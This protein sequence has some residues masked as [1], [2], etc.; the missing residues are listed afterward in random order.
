MIGVR[1]S[2]IEGLSIN[3]SANGEIAIEESRAKLEDGVSVTD[4]GKVKI[5]GSRIGSE[6]TG[7][8]KEGI[9]V[10]EVRGSQIEGT[11]G[12]VIEEGVGNVL[13]GVKV[14]S[15]QNGI[16]IKG[17]SRA[18]LKD[19]EIESSL[20]G[21]DID[22]NNY[23]KI[24]GIKIKAEEA[25][26]I[27]SGEIEIIDSEI[28]GRITAK[29][30]GNVCINNSSIGSVSVCG[31]SAVGINDSEITGDAIDI[32]EN[33]EVL[34]KD[35]RAELDEGIDITGRGKLKIA[36][37][38]ILSDKTGIRKDGNE[39]LIL[40]DT[41][42]I[43]S[44]ES[45]SIFG[46]IFVSF[47][48]CKFKSYATYT[49]VVIGN[50][51]VDAT[52]LYCSGNKG[53]FCNDVLK[54]TISDF[55]LDVFSNSLKVSNSN[56]VINK[57]KFETKFLSQNIILDG[58]SKVNFYNGKINIDSNFH[59]NAVAGYSFILTT[60]NSETVFDNIDINNNINN[61]VNLFSC[62]NKSNVL[63]TDIHVS[64]F[65]GFM[66]SNDYSKVYVNDSNI[67]SASSSFVL[68]GNSEVFVEKSSVTNSVDFQ[69]VARDCA[70]LFLNNMKGTCDSCFSLERYSQIYTQN[71]VFKVK[72]ESIVSKD[73]AV[74]VNKNAR[75]SNLKN[76]N[77]N[78]LK[79]L[80][81][82]KFNVILSNFLLQI[83]SLVI[84]T[85]N[86]LFFKKIYESIYFMAVKLY[87]V[88]VKNQNI[89]GIFLRRGMLNN[90]WIAGS[91]DID[92]FTMIK[93]NNIRSEIELLFNIHK[94]YKSIKRMFPLYGENIIM[95]Q[96]ELKFYMEYGDGRVNDI[97][98][99]VVL[100]GQQEIISSSQSEYNE[101]KNRIDTA[102]EILNSYILFSGNYFNKKN[103]INDIC[104]A[105]ATI[106]ILKK[107]NPDIVMIDSRT[108]WLKRYMDT[109]SY[110][111]KN[112]LDPLIFLLQKNI[113]LTLAD[114]NKIFNFIFEKI[115]N[116]SKI[117]NEFIIANTSVST[118]KVNKQHNVNN[119]HLSSMID[120]L[121]KKLNNEISSVI[122]DNPGVCKVIVESD[123]STNNGTQY[124]YD[125]FSNIKKLAVLDSTPVLFF[126]KSMYQMLIFSRFKN[127]PL[128]EYKLSNF[129][130]I[131]KKRIF[132]LNDDVEY[133]IHGKEIVSKLLLESL[134]DMS[135]Q[136][137]IIDITK[138]F[139][140]IKGQVLE[141]LF[142]VMELNLYF[143]N[144][145]INSDIH[146][147]YDSFKMFDLS[148]ED[149]TALTT[150]LNVFNNSV[151]SDKEKIMKIMFFIKSIKND[152]MK[153]FINERKDTIK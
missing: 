129:S 119:K 64:G 139:D 130:N 23:E 152:L 127:M 85:R 120:L 28:E 115:N 35:S 136:I 98:R 107:I 8:N 151:L 100:Y 13:R 131:Y 15:S 135:F 117:N 22:G 101:I 89:L 82:Y 10:I 56:L 143:K 133:F 79:L 137:N 92:Y 17:E 6:N 106:D 3:A 108:G 34:L 138:R 37:S 57:F 33:G 9:E 128:E 70:N 61:R 26:D 103:I 132:F 88:F 146:K 29:G 25:V 112:I 73:S 51:T 105:K 91:S 47:I 74:I 97:Y 1:E 5:T 90:D 72:N 84:K 144:D 43:S 50:V 122:I 95:N 38:E 63:I 4:L 75:W 87:P 121:Q 54:F 104:F 65:F 109:V 153:E 67:R 96:S 21:I 80:K 68:S 123:Y 78:I 62:S 20:L 48:N 134:A 39:N 71:S 16:L 58:N 45:I 81:N 113:R 14:K 114:R 125:I 124:L 59:L 149:K 46:N 30:I 150:I 55:S 7:I 41:N 44:D 76:T 32:S 2:E 142:N 102:S 18:E 24:E 83:Q 145:I 11:N 99:S 52:G 27:G 42:V 19:I 36:K 116:F 49:I 141:V 94:K 40:T 77:Y 118:M 31:L 53:L 148:I 93:N 60:G 69:Y 111:E 12:I 66:D 147:R 140:S 110:D 126:T 86:I